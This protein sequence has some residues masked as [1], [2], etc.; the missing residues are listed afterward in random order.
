MRILD[1]ELNNDQSSWQ[2]VTFPRSK[3]DITSIKISRGVEIDNI[4]FHYYV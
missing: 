4:S 1:Y 3:V 2:K